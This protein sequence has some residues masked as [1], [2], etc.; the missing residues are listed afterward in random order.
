MLEANYSSRNWIPSS[1]YENY[2][3]LPGNFAAFYCGWGILSCYSDFGMGEMTCFGQW[4]VEG[5]NG[6]HVFSRSL[7]KHPHKLLG[8]CDP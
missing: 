7:K 3:S 1:M 4:N 8:S 6:V 2:L 5:S